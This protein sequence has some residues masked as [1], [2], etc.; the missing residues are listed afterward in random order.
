MRYWDSV[1]RRYVEHDTTAQETFGPLEEHTIRPLD[2]E[3]EVRSGRM[4]VNRARRLIGLDPF[5]SN[6]N[7]RTVA[8][9]TK[10]K[11]DTLQTFSA[12]L[13]WPLDARQ[14]EVHIEDVAHSL[15][16]QCR[17]AGHC[18]QFYSVAEHSVLIANWIWW[19]GP[20]AD[21]LCGLLH[22]ATEAYLVDMP[23]P[24]KR[25]LPEYQR[26]EAALWKVI[27]ARFGL[28][29]VMPDVVHE[30]DNRI[31]GD[32]LVNMRPMAWHAKHNDPLGVELQ[33]WSPEQAEDAFLKTYVML[34]KMGVAG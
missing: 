34:Q 16:L 3:A 7:L 33:F 20:A 19:H 26:H 28:P 9:A 32:E 27:A 12:R 17:F 30:A 29:E 31:I 22:D 13:F 4:T 18:K 15:S 1:A 11:G 6:D 21:A 23:R 8:D 14:D 10:R 2:L 25:S 24:V 5:P